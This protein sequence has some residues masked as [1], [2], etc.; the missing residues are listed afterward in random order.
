MNEE[1]RYGGPSSWTGIAGLASGLMA[2][3]LPALLKSIG[4]RKMTELEK[5]FAHLLGLVLKKYEALE[6]E[7]EELRKRPTR[8]ELDR[9]VRENLNMG[10]QLRS[11]G[12]VNEELR[13]KLGKRK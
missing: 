5:A 3:A 10:D 2:Y 4:G 6:K 1:D 11:T 8:E 13:A 9:V 12:R 7:A